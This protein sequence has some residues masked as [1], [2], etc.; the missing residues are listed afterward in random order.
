[1]D[2]NGLPFWQLSGRRD[3]GL[4]S[5]TEAVRVAEGLQFSDEKQH[6]TLAREQAAPAI[7]EHEIFSRRM[8][9]SPSP[10]AD[11]L[12]GFA[13][14]SNANDRI[15][16]S[17]FFP[18]SI[19]IDLAG[20][21]AA[22][23]PSD[24]AFGSDE[25]IYAARDGIV[26]MHD[27]RDRW[28]DARVSHDDFNAHLL[29][30]APGGGAWAFD[31]V[32]RRLARVTGVPLRFSG[33]DDAEAGRFEPVDPNPDPPRMIL[34]RRARV[35]DDF[36]VV[37]MASSPG[38][39]LALLAWEAGEEAVILLLE[40]SVFVVHCRLAGLEFPFSIAWQGEGEVALLASDGEEPAKQAFVYNMKTGATPERARLPDGR[41]FPLLE[42]W[43]GK[44]ANAF[45]DQA[46][47]LQASG[48]SEPMG[49]RPLHP[50][51]GGSHARSGKVL[52]GPIDS[53]KPGTI[54]HRIYADAALSHG[55]AI[56]LQLQASD[57]PSA[58]EIAASGDDPDWAMHVIG[59]AGDDLDDQAVP[60]AAWLSQ[61]SE[62]G[63]A[64]SSLA[65][66]QRPEKS[67]LFT[68]LAQNPQ[69]RVRRITGRYLWITLGMTG[70][71]LASP[72]LSA[73]RVYADRQSLRDRYLPA[74]YQEQLTGGDAS[75]AG[76]ATRHDFLERMLESFEG[77][78]TEIEGRIAN[79][80]EVTDPAS[81]PDSA[82]PWIGG[83]IA[84]EIDPAESPERA[85]QRLLASPHCRALHGTQGGL[86]AALELATGGRVLTGGQIS[87]DGIVP[88]PGS[89][90]LARFGGSKLRGL[91]LAISQG[92]G[93]TILAGGAVTRGDIVIVEGFRLRRTFAT[94]L[95]ADLVDEEDPLTLGTAVSGNSHVG[96]TLIL[97]DRA[98]REL[99]A[100]YRSEIDSARGDTEAI[101]RFYER[102]AWR[103]LVLV[104]GIEDKSEIQRL[105]D[106]VA[107]AVPAHVEAQI[108]AAQTALIV[109]AASLVGIDSYLSQDTDFER[110]RLNQSLIGEGDYV[111][112]SGHLDRRAD[113]P[114]SLP[115]LARAD[116]PEEVW[117][118]GSFTLSA[119]NSTAAKGRRINRHIWMWD[120]EEKNG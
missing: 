119:I 12:G 15:E 10:I 47:H 34:N 43:H 30:P 72:E 25:V 69:S 39:R 29:A 106:V 55:G 64:G 79:G 57:Q 109:G 102:L 19:P 33:L 53:G 22:E 89:L 83:W 113:G 41:V 94:I 13:W 116:G 93:C 21:D 42:T 66:P 111:A 105:E 7:Q 20:D 18:G 87:D 40:D 107:R 17:G 103:V 80:W 23:S 27:N 95:G 38:G 28:P 65:C 1:M 108:F 26:I 104:R 59:K 32:E 48:I 58:P 90:V 76:P 114:V 96:D 62:I 45:G 78:F 31:R 16:A 51:S 49:I 120:K 75:A 35:S 74:F 36:D 11:G 44:F 46:H 77:S 117:H 97:G 24:I 5:E 50:L 3:F 85:R 60:Q 101:K 54:W 82:L 86:M 98:G 81:A 61:Q 56:Q 73:L 2:V 110:V 6:L 115:P 84:E 118:G 63:N 112:G 52:V 67:G 92:G 100:L 14:W 8:A 68:L 37:A 4:S 88:P 99:F 71:G 91:L 70:N 9:T